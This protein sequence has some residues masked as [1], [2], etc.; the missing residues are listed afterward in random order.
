MEPIRLLLVLLVLLGNTVGIVVTVPPAVVLSEVDDERFETVTPADL[1]N[2]SA[3]LL[4]A[5]GTG[6]TEQTRNETDGGTAGDDEPTVVEGEPDISVFATNRTVAPGD[7]REFLVRVVNSGHLETTGPNADPADEDRVTT[8]RNVQVTLDDDSSPVEV[9]GGTVGLGDL[10]SGQSAEAGFAIVVPADADADSYDLPVDIEY[11]YV[12]ESGDEAV[13]RE[14]ETVTEDVELVVTETARFEVESVDADVQVGETDDVEVDIENVGEEDL[15]DATVRL[16]SANRNLRVDGSNRT[17]RYVG[18]WDAGDDAE[19]EFQATAT[20]ESVPQ[21]YAVEAVVSY[22][23]EDGTRR[24]SRTLAFGVTP[25]D[26]QTF[27][28]DD[29]E[30]PLRVGEQATVTGELE[31]DGPE[32]ATDAVLRIRSRDDGVVPAREEV[33]LGDLDDGD[34]EGFEFPVRVRENAEPGARQLEFVVRYRDENGD[35]RA[36]DS[37]PAVVEVDGE[38]T[39]FELV[40]VNQ[41]LQVGADGTVALT[42]DND[43]DE[44][45][46]DARVSIRSPNAALTLGGE[47]NASR[48][49]GEWPDGENRTVRVPAELAADATADSYPLV[50]T[51]GYTDEDDDTNRSDPIRFG[52]TPAG[53][54]RFRVGNVTGAL[55]VGEEGLVTGRLTNAGPRNVTDAVLVLA[56][57]SRNVDPRE[58]EYAVGRLASGAS[59]RFAFPVDVR[60]TAEPGPRQLTVRVEWRDAD[61]DRRESDSLPANVRVGP[62]TDAFAVRAAS[63]TVAAGSTETVTLVV[64]NT[65]NETLRNVNAKLFATEPLTAEDD[66]AFVDSLEPNE[67]VRLRFDVSASGGANAKRF[68]LK[69]DFQYDEPD[70]ETKLSD[71]YQV[72]VR[73]TE[74]EG[75]PFSGVVSVSAA[76][77]GVFLPVV[78][79][80]L[81]HRRQQ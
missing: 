50:A 61:E 41:A 7:R 56:N 71:T 80:Y 9:R 11:E 38:E 27:E 55:S 51:V 40:T 25:D 10:P 79:G 28:L 76:L 5:L 73:V 8:A 48:F 1:A 14:S 19:I 17:D 47:G 75:G 6:R 36:S 70:G 26:E 15:T 54:Q 64:R 37:L 20:N 21:E 44:D 45:L 46:T 72:G 62:E 32:P 4:T 52:V 63:A 35:V 24:Q 3:E 67:T 23:D 81:W 53:E 22:T 39:D 18:D 74:S 34:D 60:E 78:G 69:V 13:D 31:N 49:V 33:V 57:G 58:N 12:P 16:T 30:G 77:V 42:L 59:T 68:P 65:R 29:V 66:G 2:A 43:R